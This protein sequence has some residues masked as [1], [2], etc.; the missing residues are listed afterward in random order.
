MDHELLRNVLI[1]A[2][3]GYVRD[4][5]EGSD[6]TDNR[7]DA[8]ADVTYLIN[9]HFSVGAAYQYSTRDSDSDTAEFD[10][11]IFTVRVRAQL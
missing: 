8:G 10:S 5:F 2:E 9:R 3:G 7:Y 4:D 1:G 11:N 6:R